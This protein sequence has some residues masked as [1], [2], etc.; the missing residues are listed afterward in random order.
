[1][2]VTVLLLGFGAA[3]ECHEGT[4]LTALVFLGTTLAGALFAG[5]L[6]H[7]L[8]PEVFSGP[9]FARAWNR[10]WSG[11]SAGA[12]GLMGAFAARARRPWPLLALF[13]LWELA[14]ALLYLR[15]YTSA[16]HI[17]ALLI[18]FSALRWPSARRSTAVRG[19]AS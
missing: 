5:V 9:F 2:Y 7:L 1:V 14:V 10:T 11:G 16:F 19:E 12:F 8:Y 18:G 13:G 17:P 6:L 15:E 3:F 4:R